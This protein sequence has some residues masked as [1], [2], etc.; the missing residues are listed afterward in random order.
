M[1]LQQNIEQNLKHNYISNFF[2]VTFYLLANS[3]RAE[4]T[5]LPL[6]ISK[7]TDSTLAIGVLSSIVSTGALIPQLFT[8]NWVQRTP[9][10][11]FISVNVGFFIE[12]LPLVCLVI[13]AGLAAW[14]KTVAL[15]FGMVCITWYVVGSGIS[16]VAWQD[17]IAKIIPTQTRGRFMGTTFFVGTGAGVI[18]SIAASRI[19][20]NFSFPT[21]FV[22]TFSLAALFIIISWVFLA[23]TKEPPDPP[24]NISSTKV[25]DWAQ[26][27]EIINTDINYRRYIISAAINSLGSMAVG[28][29]AVFTI[30]RWQV[31]NSQVGLYNTFLLVGAAF[32]NLLY[33]WM[34]DRVGN[35]FS[36]EI[37]SLISAASMTFAILAKS[38]TVFYLVFALRGIYTAGSFLSGM[39][40]TFEFSK[41][42]VRPTY[43]GLSNTMIGIVAGLAPILGGLLASW[44]DYTWMF[45]IA[46]ALSLFGY[47]TLRYWVV[48]PRSNA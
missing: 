32:G 48:E 37:N 7:L 13:A 30:D 6:F 43:I 8:A 16:M 15:Y 34:A 23:I 26:V 9:I 18:G 19:L 42:E 20:D 33:G 46:A 17:M 41:P 3:F 28:F 27:K 12:R 22:L 2:V 25:I 35:K 4:H 45:G 24:R 21:N 39:N 38:P 44:L 36:L 10:K 29:L 5:I 14:S 47:L 31:S 40:I 11:K 1:S